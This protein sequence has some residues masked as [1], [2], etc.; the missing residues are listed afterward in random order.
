MDA[1]HW[2]NYLIAIK[3]AQSSEVSTVDI[4]W[5]V[6]ELV[7]VRDRGYGLNIG[8]GILFFWW[9]NAI[10]NFFIRLQLV[11]PQIMT[12]WQC[13]AEFTDVKLHECFAGSLQLFL[14]ES[15]IC[16]PY[17]LGGACIIFLFSSKLLT[18]IIFIVLLT[19]ISRWY[20]NWGNCDTIHSETK[21][22]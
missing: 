13:K 4:Q 1:V 12:C 11:A 8:I 19:I 6:N 10:R 9:R 18:S 7:E 2:R 21:E 16:S 17:V 3:M 20:H 5:F 22:K 15:H 14:N